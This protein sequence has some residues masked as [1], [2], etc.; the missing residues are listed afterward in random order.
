MKWWR[1][2][3]LLALLALGGQGLS[4]WARAIPLEDVS[5]DHRLA[6]FALGDRIATAPSAGLD[7]HLRKLGF[8]NNGAL[9]TGWD[10]FSP[11]RKIE[12]FY[13]AAEAAP[14]PNGTAALAMLARRL[15]LD[16]HPALLHDRAIAVLPIDDPV[17]NLEFAAA[18]PLPM[19]VPTDVTVRRAIT[20]LA[21]HV[22]QG[23]APSL[24][25][26]VDRLKVPEEHAYRLMRSAAPTEKI[27]LD[28]VS[29]ARSPIGATQELLRYFAECA[30]AT[31]NDPAVQAFVRRY[32]GPTDEPTVLEWSVRAPRTPSYRPPPGSPVEG[33]VLAQARTVGTVHDPRFDLGAVARQGRHSPAMGRDRP[34]LNA[35]SPAPGLP[36]LEPPASATIVLSKPD[37]PLPP[38]PAA[39]DPSLRA[40]ILS[41]ARAVA[42]TGPKQGEV[43]HVAFLDA[44]ARPAGPGYDIGKKEITLLETSLAKGAALPKGGMVDLVG[45]ALSFSDDSLAS[46]ALDIC[47]KRP[48]LVLD[49]PKRGSPTKATLPFEM[50]RIFA[51][52]WQRVHDRGITTFYLSIDPTP[53]TLRAGYEA[54]QSLPRNRL[55]F[56]DD[57]PAGE[58]R[59][60]VVTS[61]E[62][63]GTLLGRALFDAD[64]LFKS[65]ALGF[66]V[67]HGTKALLPGLR[68]ERDFLG[69]QEPPPSDLAEEMESGAAV[70]F[71]NRWCRYYWTSAPQKLVF[72]PRHQAIRL[73]GPGAIA[74]AEAMIVN[75]DA[76]VP[77]PRG[78]WCA[79][80]KAEARYLNKRLVEGGE[81]TPALSQL[82]LIASMQNFSK[83]ATDGDLPT[84]EAFRNALAEV[85]V[86]TPVNVPRWTSGIRSD[87][88]PKL[89]ADLRKGHLQVHIY[90]SDDNA[91]TIAQEAWESDFDANARAAGFTPGSKQNWVT[92]APLLPK[93]R[94]LQ[95]RVTDDLEGVLKKNGYPAT[96]Q[97]KA[98]EPNEDLGIDGA[99]LPGN[100]EMFLSSPVPHFL[101]YGV[102]GG[103]LFEAQGVIENKRCGDHVRPLSLPDGRPV[104]RCEVDGPH[105]WSFP[106]TETT[107]AGEHLSVGGGR[108]LD[109]YADRGVVRVLVRLGKTA[110]ASH[111]VRF[112]GTEQFPGG[113]EW[114]R[115]L[116][117]GDA[118]REE[119][120]LYW[121]EPKA[122]GPVL[123]AA[124][125]SLQDATTGD[126]PALPV[127]DLTIHVR[128]VPGEDSLIVV[129]ITLADL[130]STLEDQWARA[131]SQQDLDASVRSIATDLQWG[132]RERAVHNLQVLDARLGGASRR[133]ELLLERLS[134]S[135][136]EED[137]DALLLMRQRVSLASAASL[138]RPQGNSAAKVHSMVRELERV[139]REDVYISALSPG[140]QARLLAAEL[141]SRSG[142]WRGKPATA[143]A[144]EIQRL[145][146]EADLALRLRDSLDTPIL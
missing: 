124:P 109:I 116:A 66:D 23:T 62:L 72:D 115:R 32:G 130:E 114:R 18:A 120:T 144:E 13:R 27:L 45:A 112:W 15:S 81:M 129:E 54:D 20:R 42:P 25:Q 74:R 41:R 85:D 11:V 9:P 53:G 48:C 93:A 68:T 143:L 77:Y 55:A 35:A 87:V 146:S 79:S 71:E 44:N 1:W 58:R 107:V 2:G 142:Q 110:A 122:A 123:V 60:R 6:V 36:G 90:A 56:G 16:G 125:L 43:I 80:A 31:L 98:W 94:L 118:T 40:E 59:N 84:T 132:F 37:G 137:L 26:I 88:A 49:D 8:S 7:D 82:D 69:W 95:R 70:S 117:V 76:L 51:E 65:A 131:Q 145:R 99:E 100:D 30:P 5:S 73:I 63:E 136:G 22:E 21:K 64:V 133:Q 111:E 61:G 39:L 46:A 105:F 34:F 102:H 141:A 121:I 3:A 75:G 67:T 101:P 119:S 96:Q 89:R 138:D 78:S 91:I 139:L 83:W 108:V 50:S 57:L 52:I 86:K 28:L 14:K 4:R 97:L 24:T 106:S 19:E 33:P 12:T 126:S 140:V 135:A 29:Q 10:G 47:G 17:P 128:K 127:Q 92:P 134:I 113:L 103:I 38:T 104:F